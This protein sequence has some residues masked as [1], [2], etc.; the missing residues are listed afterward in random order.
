MNEKHIGVGCGVMILD[1]NKV[2]MCRRLSRGYNGY[3][4]WALVGGNVEFGETPE[5]AAI[6]EVKEETDLDIDPKDISVFCFSNNIY[7]EE[8]HYISIGLITRKWRG[9]V[10]NMEPHKCAE[11][12]WFDLD[13]LPEN[14]FVPSAEFIRNYKTNA[15]YTRNEG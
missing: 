9:V 12:K 6:R 7:N 8:S 5:Q 2:L 15:F 1:G 3:G 13:A 11:L 10:K 4:Q 14:I